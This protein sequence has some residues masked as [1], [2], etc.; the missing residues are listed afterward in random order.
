MAMTD[1]EKKQAQGLAII[2][3]IAAAVLFFMFWRSPIAVEAAEK[4][5]RMDTL[6]AQVD[7]ANTLL[8]TS[9]T[10]QLQAS[11][12]VYRSNLGLMRRLVPSGNELPELLENI[13][14]RANLR[15]LKIIG[16]NPQDPTN[17]GAFRVFTYDIT[18]VGG[19]DH[20]GEFLT[21]VASLTRIMVPN[22]LSLELLDMTR[23]PADLITDT[24]VTALQAQMLIKT[25]V[26]I[27]A[28][29]GDAGGVPGG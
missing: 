19:Y 22:Q 10:E 1:K 11:I 20:I 15:S 17:E 23:V 12:A 21:D 29:A 28:D 5:L 8:E 6:Q 13:A 16:V 7:S 25:F 2:A 27:A 26:K 24:T 3:G 4:R 18:V 14:Q 9:S